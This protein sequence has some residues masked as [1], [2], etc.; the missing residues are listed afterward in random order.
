MIDKEM[1]R[2]VHLDI[3]TKDIP[4]YSSPIM[5]TAEKEFKFEKIS[6]LILG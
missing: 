5:L 3:L 6:S 1:E 4:P 2:L